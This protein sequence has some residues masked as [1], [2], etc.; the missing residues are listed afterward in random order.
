[1]QVHPECRARGC[2]RLCEDEPGV[3]SISSVPSTRVEQP[4]ARD[5]I[6]PEQPV[7]QD[8]RRKK[9]FPL[10]LQA[11]QQW[12]PHVGIEFVEKLQVACYVKNI[13]TVTDEMLAKA[14]GAAHKPTQKFEGLF[15]TTVPARLAVI[16][17]AASHERAARGKDPQTEASLSACD[18]GRRS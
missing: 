3:I 18:F 2:G 15:L 7:A 16:L 17:E 1:M 6:P 9:S 10:T 8:S 5:E 4:V 11:V 13:K 12:F 14:V